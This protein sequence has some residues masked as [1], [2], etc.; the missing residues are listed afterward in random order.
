MGASS[1]PLISLGDATGGI[2][3]PGLGLVD[4][5]LKYIILLY[6]KTMYLILEVCLNLINLIRGINS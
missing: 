1:R 3:H 6:Y 2:T 4:F 5:N